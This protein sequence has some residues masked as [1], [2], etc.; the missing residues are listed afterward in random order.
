MPNRIA[1]AIHL[2]LFFAV[3]ACAGPAQ[4]MR[5]EQLYASMLRAGGVESSPAAAIKE[6][7]AARRSANDQVGKDLDA[8]SGRTGNKDISSA[9]VFLRHEKEQIRFHEYSEDGLRRLLAATDEFGRM[10]VIAQLRSIVDMEQQ[11]HARARAERPNATELKASADRYA[12]LVVD[13]NAKLEVLALKQTSLECK[14]TASTVDPTAKPE[15]SNRPNYEVVYALES[16]ESD[17]TRW[18]TFDKLSSPTSQ[19]LT[20]GYYVMWCR[21]PQPDG[22]SLD[23]PRKRVVVKGPTSVDLLV[24]QAKD[25]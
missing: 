23:G 24:P 18:R 14:V 1:R 20:A 19:T 3:V 8:A 12:S 25:H 13:L 6:W 16:W 21:Q 9:Q 2:I 10:H 5:D 7:V 11:V 15:T 17:P 22:S 4:T